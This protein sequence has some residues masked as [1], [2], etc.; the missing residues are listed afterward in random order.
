MGQTILGERGVPIP[1]NQYYSLDSTSMLCSIMYQK[2][3]ISV[4]QQGQLLDYADQIDQVTKLYVMLNGTKYL[5]ALCEFKAL[6]SPE[7]VLIAGI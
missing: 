3:S 7:R 4:W 5:R 1:L 2:Q 6:Q